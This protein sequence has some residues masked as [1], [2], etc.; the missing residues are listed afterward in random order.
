MFIKTDYKLVNISTWAWT[1]IV[2]NTVDDGYAVNAY[3][4][5]EK[6]PSEI[7]VESTENEAQMLLDEIWEALKRGENFYEIP[8]KEAEQG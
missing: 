6:E 3:Y 8:A 1:D 4:R 2:V 5:G 7:A